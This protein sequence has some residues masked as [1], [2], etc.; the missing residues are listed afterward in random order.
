M[1]DTMATKKRDFQTLSNY[2]V[3]R[4]TQVSLNFDID[5]EKKRL[6]GN[7]VLKMKVVADE[8]TTIILD[9]K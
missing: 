7:V 6:S 9:T 2:D 8:C 4:T 5:F 1:A 3:I